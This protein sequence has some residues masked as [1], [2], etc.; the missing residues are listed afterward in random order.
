MRLVEGH[1]R[2]SDARGRTSPAS[3]LGGLLDRRQPR[4]SPIA[5]IRAQGRR[6][7]P[8]D[9]EQAAA[10]AWKVAVSEFTVANGVITHKASGRSMTY[11]KVAEAAAKLEPPKE[12]KLKDPKE[13]KIAGKP[14]K[15]LDTAD[16]VTGKAIYS[17]W[18]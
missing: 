17:A 4:H 10:D 5:R 9:A 8:R 11:G 14:L 6:H 7:R 15:R 3:G 16:K 1:A 2:D 18:T 12:V 13:W